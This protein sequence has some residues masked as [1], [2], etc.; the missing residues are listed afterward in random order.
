MVTAKL[1]PTI[2]I[3][4][5]LNPLKLYE[6]ICRYCWVAISERKFHG[7]AIWGST[8]HITIKSVSGVKSALQSSAKRKL[9]GSRRTGSNPKSSTPWSLRARTNSPCPHPTSV[10]PVGRSRTGRTASKKYSSVGIESDPSVPQ[11]AVQ[12]APS[13]WIRPA[14]YWVF[15]RYRSS[16]AHPN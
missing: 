14:S 10:T 15:R 16:G 11:T 1:I 4:N 8:Q 7:S 13:N 6:N 3:N 12:Y 9:H 2:V 5:P